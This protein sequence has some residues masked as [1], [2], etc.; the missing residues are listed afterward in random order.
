[1]RKELQWPSII[2]TFGF[3]IIFVSYGIRFSYPILMPK[4][5]E[6]L[7]LSKTESGLILG[8]YMIGYAIA[9]PVAGFLT[10]RLGGRRVITIFCFIMAVGTL[11]MGISDN[12]FMASIF[13]FVA[14]IGG[15]SSWVPIVALIKKWF[16][17]ERR[18]RILGL[19]DAGVTGGL[20]SMGILLPIT[21]NLY[22]W[23]S[24]WFI[25]IKR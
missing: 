11:L 14:G 21:V 18:G 2:L 8:M 6:S 15:A 10:D 7:N 23:R 24:S 25:M 13:F 3:L 1:M 17:A 12:S 4:M 5:I 19:L 20:G 9:S 16:R 22:G